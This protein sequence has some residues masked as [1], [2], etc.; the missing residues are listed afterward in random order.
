M[1]DRLSNHLSKKKKPPRKIIGLVPAAG[2]AARLAPLPCSKELFPIGFRPLGRSGSLRPKVVGHYLLE[3]LRTAGIMEAFLILRRG[4]WDIPAYFG[5][6]K[7]LNMHLAYLM[8]D[9]PFGVP[10]TLDQAYPFVQD[11]M[12]AFGFPDIIFDRDDAFVQLLNCQAE[13]NADI[14][15]GLFPTDHPQ[16]W[17][18]VD[19]DEDGRIRRIV[20]KSSRVRLRYAWII[21]VWTP[22][23][24]GFLHQ[25]IADRKHMMEHGSS[26]NLPADAPELCIG[27]VIQAAI[28]NE[29]QIDSVRFPD[30]ACLDIGT[31]EDMVNALANQKEKFRAL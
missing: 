6:G 10:Y 19:V 9:L 20:I 7:M 13:S 2:K 25:Y 18:M 11:A 29:F 16:K 21:A 15:L 22:V 27:D 31:P 24:T 26:Q 23:F 14:V 28:H 12:V 17:D 3:K 1:S 8:M 4:K 30:S 5:D